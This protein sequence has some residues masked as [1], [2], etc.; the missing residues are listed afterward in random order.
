[1]SVTTALVSDASKTWFDLG[2]I[3]FNETIIDCIKQAQACTQTEE[4][5]LEGEISAWLQDD[6]LYVAMPVAE[7]EVAAGVIAT[8]MRA[9]PDWRFLTDCDE[10][11]FDQFLAEDEDDAA[12]YTDEFGA[13]CDPIYKKDGALP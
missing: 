6:D 7:A 8:W 12:E 2:K 1:M 10:E 13:D 3:Y 11:F 9:H 4:M 5:N